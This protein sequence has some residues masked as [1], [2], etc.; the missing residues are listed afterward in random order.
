MIDKLDNWLNKWLQC[1]QLP[2][3]VKANTLYRVTKIDLFMQL[4]VHPGSLLVSLL[5]RLLSGHTLEPGN[6]ANS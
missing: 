1:V 2:L 3:V 6:K 5:P 4:L